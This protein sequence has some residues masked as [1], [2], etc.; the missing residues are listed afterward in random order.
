VVEHL[1][2]RCEL[3]RCERRCGFGAARAWRAPVNCARSVFVEELKDAS[4]GLASRIKGGVSTSSR[5]GVRTLIS[6]R[7]ARHS[8]TEDSENGMRRERRGGDCPRRPRRRSHSRAHPIPG[9]KEG[10]LTASPRSRMSG[11]TAAT[12][13][14]NE[15]S[16]VW[17]ES[18]RAST[19]AASAG[20]A[21]RE[22]NLGGGDRGV[23]GLGKYR[24]SGMAF[25]RLERRRRQRLGGAQIRA[26]GCRGAGV[27][28]L[29][30]GWGGVG[31]GWN[32]CPSSEAAQRW[33]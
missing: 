21:P 14:S 24:G 19:A 32:G 28:G 17:P 18:T 13:S 23:Q 31:K 33:R 26:P 1:L 12:N 10:T 30:K 27:R 29:S 3:A 20:E 8:D 4:Q 7:A 25:R 15:I 11:P 9:G 22:T 2:R 5:E 6:G 16:P